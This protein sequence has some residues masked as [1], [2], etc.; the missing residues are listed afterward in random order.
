MPHGA[1]RRL[2]YVPLM[3]KELQE[4]RCT[5]LYRSHLF[6]LINLRVVS[7]NQHTFEIMSRRAA[8]PPVYE[9]RSH[10]RLA[11][12]KV[13]ETGARS[14]SKRN[15]KENVEVPE[16]TARKEIAQRTQ[17]RTERNRSVS[18]NREELHSGLDRSFPRTTPERRLKSLPRYEERE[19]L[20][21]DV[22][23]F[24]IILFASLVFFLLFSSLLQR[25][26]NIVAHSLPSMVSFQRQRLPIRLNNDLWNPYLE[27]PGMQWKLHPNGALLIPVEDLS[28]Y[29]FLPKPYDNLTLAHFGFIHQNPWRALNYKMSKD[30]LLTGNETREAQ[31]RD[32]DDYIEHFLLG[33]WKEHA[34]CS[35]E[36]KNNT[37]YLEQICPF[38]SKAFKDAGDVLKSP[39]SAAR[40]A[41]KNETVL[42]I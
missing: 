2:R 21:L 30:Y 4:I 19:T 28:L 20:I 1:M 10:T 33:P 38:A 22:P 25:V 12:P 3:F 15:T 36:H 35:A 7:S 6:F 34:L 17:R 23:V 26:G 32:L 16:S 39:E 24:R 42:D 37:Q 40:T 31:I 41:K 5:S 14:R 8:Q 29:R 9:T 27:K 11:N 18:R 13:Q